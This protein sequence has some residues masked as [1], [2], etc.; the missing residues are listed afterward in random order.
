MAAATGI[1]D[2][3]ERP[4][5]WKSDEAEDDTVPEEDRPLASA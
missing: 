4:A 3:A 1:R 5:E 2:E